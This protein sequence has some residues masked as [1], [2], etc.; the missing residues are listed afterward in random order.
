MNKHYNKSLFTHK[1][2]WLVAATPLLVPGTVTGGPPIPFGGWSVNNGAISATCASGALCGTPTS[3]SGL[4]QREIT[5]GTGNGRY[6][7]SILTDSNASGLPGTVA[8]ASESFVKQGGFISQ[9]TTSAGESEATTTS[10][11][12]TSGLSVSQVVRGTG[13]DKFLMTAQ[14]NTGWAAVAGQ[15]NIEITQ[16]FGGAAISSTVDMV[17]DFKY[18]ANLDANGNRTGFKLDIGQT[19]NGSQFNGSGGGSGGGGWGGGGGGWGWS[20]AGSVNM[21]VMR[22]VAGDMLTKSGSASLSGGNSRS[23]GGGGWGGT[24][25]R[26][27]SDSSGNGGSISWTPGQ[28][29]KVTWVAQSGFGF[30]AYDNRSDNKNRI[31]TSSISSTGPFTWVTDPFGVKPVYQGGSSGGGSGG[32]G[33]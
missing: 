24:G 23:G 18:V 1:A 29:V 16:N 31:A 7:Q 19:V 8:F 32:W 20:G 5:A 28:D 25:G 17:G 12:E 14:I 6:M 26:S 10:S 2:L 33:W 15:P 22:E 4:L 30:Q 21:F 13:N 9:W 11:G 27:S 3:T